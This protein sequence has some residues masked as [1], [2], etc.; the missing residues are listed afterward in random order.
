[1]V[2]LSTRLTGSSTSMISLSRRSAASTAVSAPGRGH[3]RP[4]ELQARVAV[5][6]V[7]VGDHRAQRGVVPVEERGG[8]AA[9]RV[10]ALD[11]GQRRVPVVAGEDL[12]GAL[13]RLHDRDRLAHPLA[14]QVEGDDVVADHGLGHR[15]DRVPER[16]GQLVAARPGSGG[17]RWRSAWR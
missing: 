6:R 17:G 13:P 10:A 15:A 11:P 3:V 14:E 12:V 1:M 4:H 7:A 16:A 2:M 8:V 9:H 5:H